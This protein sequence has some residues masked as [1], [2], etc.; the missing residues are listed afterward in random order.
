MKNI[1]II[2][3]AAITL[4]FTACKDFL[5]EEPVMSQ[6]TELTLSSYKGLNNATLGAY[7]PLVSPNWYGASFVLDAE[8]RSGNGYRNV[9]KNSGRYTVPYDLNYTSTATPA[10]WGTAYYVISEVNNVMDNLNGKTGDGILQQDLDNL[11]AECLFLRAL[12]HFDLVRTYAKQYTVDKNALGVPYI[13]HTDPAGQPARDKVETVYNYIVTDLTDAE[14]LIADNYARTGVADA[15]SV[16]SKPAI[17]ALLSRVYLYMGEWQKSAD[18]ATL[19]IDNKKYALWE[20]AEY[21]AAYK[22]DAPVGG[23]VIFEIYGIKSN[24]Y[25]AYWDAITW[26]TSPEKDAYSDC[27]TSNDLISLYDAADVRGKLYIDNPDYPTI[28]YTTKYAGKDKG[29]P[30]VSNTIVLRLSEMYLN[31]A[32]ALSHGATISGTN[33]MADINAIREQRGV[34][35]YL[36]PADVDVLLE[37]RLELA[38]EGHFWYDLARTGRSVNRTHYSGAETNRNVPADSK[39]W[40]LPIN[41]RELDANPNLAP[42]NPGYE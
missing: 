31:R 40:A 42:N 12:A 21:A 18:Y 35:L 9:D 8:M 39:Y 27:A 30:D 38:W 16:V 19:V 4:L 13:F 23:E 5:V 33:A 25:D 10:L 20:E 24:S 6:S 41:K 26:E 14:G 36:N 37:R 2:V 3:F 34:A 7:A 29:R 15:K 28:Y 22:E 17:Q 11:K 32:E 1:I